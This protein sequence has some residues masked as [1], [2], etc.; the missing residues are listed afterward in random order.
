MVGIGLFLGQLLAI[1]GWKIIS[2]WKSITRIVSVIETTTE[3]TTTT[4][5]TT[6]AIAPEIKKYVKIRIVFTQFFS[7]I[8]EIVMNESQLLTCSSDE[9]PNLESTN[10]EF[11]AVKNQKY[12]NCD[13]N[14]SPIVSRNFLRISR[15]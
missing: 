14:F 13:E 11:S 2:S 12:K 10:P 7:R 8:P 5:V 15:K 6:F 9:I 3:T 4:S 1:S